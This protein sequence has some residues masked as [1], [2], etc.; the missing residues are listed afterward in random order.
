MR[1][2]V[3]PAFFSLCLFFLLACSNQPAKA[4][5]S[6]PEDMTPEG[7]EAA[8]QKEHEEAEEHERMEHNVTPTKPA[9][10]EAE[11]YGH[12][13]EAQ[14]HHDFAEQHEKAGAAAADAGAPKS[15]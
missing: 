11:K 6:N 7:H 8:A 1:N 15:K 5:G 4:P 10:E 13:Q 14:K 3:G 2:S 9:A 12:E